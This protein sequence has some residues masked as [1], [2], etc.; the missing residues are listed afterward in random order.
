MKILQINKFL[1]Q[2]G[3]AETYLFALTKL[4]TEAGHEIIYFSQKN[5]KNIPNYQEKYFISDLDLSRFSFSTI[6]RLGRIFWSFKA[7]KNLKKLI[8]EEQPDLIHLHNI[9]HQLS[10]SIIATAKSFGLPIVMTVHDFKLITP[11]YTLRADQ[12][13]KK[14]KDSLLID[15][16]LK[17]EF[18][19]HRAIKIYQ[20]IDLFIAPSQFVKD[21][22]IEHGY[23]ANKI[24]IIPHFIEMNNF[25]V[26]ETNDDYILAFGRL[27]ESK[28]FAD[29]IKA[30]NKL[31][32]QAPLIKIAGTGPQKSQLQQ[33]IK[34]FNLTKK[35]QLLG[36]KDK[37]ELTQLIANCK[38]V[39]LPTRVHETFSLAALESLAYGKPIIASRAGA[40]PELIT[41]KENGLLIEPGNVD[42]LANAIIK[43]QDNNLCHQL[44]LKAKESATNK[45]Y[46]PQF[47]LQSILKAYSLVKK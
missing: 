41:D 24:I 3:G 2:R 4:L 20:Q 11:N 18:A 45:K 34:Q 26:Q 19:F 22:L 30:I 12:V 15:L 8:N 44:S 32:D 6:L 13:N 36:Q 14:H 29:L 28:G 17:L 21:K 9:Y 16:L 5:S 1:Y 40:L 38:F 47:H 46:S 37:T 7:A 43:L 10:P 27:D 39:C 25:S 31:G 23:P 42:E 35:I 33:L